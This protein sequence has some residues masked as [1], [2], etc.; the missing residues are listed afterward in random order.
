M[1]K[2]EI[3]NRLRRL[4]DEARKNLNTSIAQLLKTFIIEFNSILMELK[5]NGTMGDKKGFSYNPNEDEAFD[6]SISSYGQAKIQAIILAS[7]NILMEKVSGNKGLS[8]V[9][10][11]LIG[12]SIPIFI[13]LFNF[14]YNLGIKHTE[15]EYDKEKINL[16]KQIDILEKKYDSCVNFKKNDSIVK[17]KALKK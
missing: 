8:S 12:L 14:A 15:K 9:N 7:E 3:K 10:K 6:G 17:D 11:W 16:Q 1:I 13:F 2:Q 5:M 4:V